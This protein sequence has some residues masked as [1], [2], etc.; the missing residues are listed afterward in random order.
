M[1]FITTFFRSISFWA[2]APVNARQLRY[3]LFE[4][5]V[6][7]TL[8]KEGKGT[9]LTLIHSGWDTLPPD[10]QGVA[11]LFDGGWGGFLK[12]LQQVAGRVTADKG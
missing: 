6:T 11:D 10:Q 3:Q 7:F 12:S 9:R 8:A 4:T 1:V 2:R 5:L